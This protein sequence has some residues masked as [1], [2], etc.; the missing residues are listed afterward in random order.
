MVKMKEFS[1]QGGHDPPPCLCLPTP[2]TLSDLPT[3]PLSLKIIRF[4]RYQFVTILIIMKRLETV[5]A[6][7]ARI[8][9]TMFASIRDPTSWVHTTHTTFKTMHGS[10]VYFQRILRGVMTL[11]GRKHSVILKTC[12]NWSKKCNLNSLS[13][14]SISWKMLQHKII[15]AFVITAIGAKLL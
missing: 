1:G 8:L 12:Y 9:R 11:P 5:F 10:L 4:K 15:T 3:V 7:I 14:D 6:K 13:T 2:L